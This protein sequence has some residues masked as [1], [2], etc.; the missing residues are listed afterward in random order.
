M[1]T[2]P[3]VDVAVDSSEHRVATWAAIGGVAVAVF[4]VCA[5]IASD[6]EVPAWEREAFHAVNDLPDWLYAPMWGFQLA[7][8]LFVPILVAAVAA[9]FRRWR[10]AAALVVL[11][12]L[13]LIVEKLVV[14]QLVERERPGSTSA[15]T[16]PS[17]SSEG[18]AIGVALG[19]LLVL[20]FRM[21]DRAT[22]R[23]S[24]GTTSSAGSCISS[25]GATSAAPARRR[26]RGSRGC[27]W[28]R[29]RCGHGHSL[30]SKN[31]SDSSLPNS[32]QRTKTPTNSENTARYT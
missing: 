11:V 17:T 3:D 18:A 4:A 20:A 5:V 23:S 19:A 32:A 16:T 1:T 8:L 2:E 25:A 30:V 21:P 31:R 7:G 12:P 26:H 24:P 6:G 27:G 29:A 22:V 14:K 13:K 28:P 9:V 10:L 15:P